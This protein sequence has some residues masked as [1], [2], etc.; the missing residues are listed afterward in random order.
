M[1]SFACKAYHTLCWPCSK[2]QTVDTMVAF[3]KNTKKNL[4][5][6][7]VPVYLMPVFF[8]SPV[9]VFSPAFSSFLTTVLSNYYR[10]HIGQLLSIQF[11]QSTSFVYFG[12]GEGA[13][14]WP[15]FFWLWVISS[16][17]VLTSV[18]NLLILCFSEVADKFPVLNDNYFLCWWLIDSCHPNY[19][20]AWRKNFWGSVGICSLD[21]HNSSSNTQ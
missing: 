4:R 21:L 10:T 16:F 9:S 11:Y 19:S 8:W 14:T 2:P 15:P 12:G 20:G 3:N 7:P 17:R 5:L 6:R 1:I 13:R 18:V